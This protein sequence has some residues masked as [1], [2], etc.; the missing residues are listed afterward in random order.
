MTDQPKNLQP[1]TCSHCGKR[2]VVMRTE[3]SVLPVEIQNKQSV[4]FTDEDRFNSKLHTSH[5]LNCKGMQ[6]DW[7]VKREWFMKKILVLF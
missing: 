4:P 5:L 1:Y 6:K 7:P 2:I 3:R